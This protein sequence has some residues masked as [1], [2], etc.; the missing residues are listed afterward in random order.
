MATTVFQYCDK[1]K[2]TEVHTWTSDLIL[3][4]NKCK[5]DNRISPI[6]MRPKKQD[7]VVFTSFKGRRVGEAAILQMQREVE[8][9]LVEK[10]A[11]A[12]EAKAGEGIKE[13]LDKVKEPSMKPV[14]GLTVMER[15][16]LL[17]KGK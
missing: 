15:M 11:K 13:Q 3:T 14:T 2:D 8:I 9:K 12:E 5:K 10:Y 1:C 4:C 17:R 6:D 7:P 16:A